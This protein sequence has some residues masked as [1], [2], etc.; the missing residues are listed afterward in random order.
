MWDQNST[1]AIK[2]GH[3]KPP[4]RKTRIIP[5]GITTVV[6][7]GAIA[8]YVVIHSAHGNPVSSVLNPGTTFKDIG[9]T[10]DGFGGYSYVTMDACAGQLDTPECTPSRYYGA[11]SIMLEKVIDPAQGI[12]NTDI[13]DPGTRFVVAEFRQT[14]KSDIALADGVVS[15]ATVRGSQSFMTDSYVVGPVLGGSDGQLYEPTGGSRTT[16]DCPAFPANSNGV[17]ATGNQL[18]AGQSVTGCYRYDLP[19]SVNISYFEFAFD[20]PS[21]PTSGPFT[22]V[23]WAKN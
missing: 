21:E 10:Y 17:S 6:V 19:D 2:H 7:A 13:P 22:T 9:K 18:K 20:N 14:N 3:R 11:E 1:Y 12:N 16:A 8:A 4:K 23:T 5:I 15:S